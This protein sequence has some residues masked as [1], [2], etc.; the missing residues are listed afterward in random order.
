[1]HVGS[2]QPQSF[3]CHALLVHTPHCLAHD[4]HWSCLVSYRSA[5]TALAP[6]THTRKI[7]RFVV[8]VCRGQIQEGLK[9]AKRCVGLNDTELQV[10]ERDWTA[11]CPGLM[12]GVPCNHLPWRRCGYHAVQYCCRSDTARP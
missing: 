10:G 7:G 4:Y 6:L 11:P 5:A 8:Q 12:P 2:I 9:G 3:Y 1:M